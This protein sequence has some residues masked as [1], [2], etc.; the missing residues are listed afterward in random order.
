M[1]T[2]EQ[3]RNWKLEINALNEFTACT[4][5]HKNKFWISGTHEY[6]SPIFSMCSPLL[7]KHWLNTYYLANNG[8]TNNSRITSPFPWGI[9]NLVVKFAGL[10]DTDRAI[11]KPKTKP[12]CMSYFTDYKW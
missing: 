1:T 4:N 12:T 2:I 7:P 10:Q 3:K 11:T 6:H 8:K 9:H 5:T